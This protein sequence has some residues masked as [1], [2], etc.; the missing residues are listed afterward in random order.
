VGRGLRDEGPTEARS[1][2]ALSLV[3]TALAGAVSMLQVT[4]DASPE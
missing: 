2:G 1:L 4:E 3:N